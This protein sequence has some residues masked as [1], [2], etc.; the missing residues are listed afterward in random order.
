MNL[1]VYHPILVKDSCRQVEGKRMNSN[2]AIKYMY[3]YCS[4]C[5]SMDPGTI[6]QTDDRLVGGGGGEGRG[7]QADSPVCGV[8]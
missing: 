6:C 5:P 2:D 3:H 4:N 7:G 8:L 1:D